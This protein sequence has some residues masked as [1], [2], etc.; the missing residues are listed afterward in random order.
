MCVLVWFG[1]ICWDG[2]TGGGGLGIHVIGRQ[3]DLDKAFLAPNPDG[4]F[5]EGTGSSVHLL[6]D[7]GVNR[8]GCRAVQG[9]KACR[10]S[11][12]GRWEWERSASVRPRLLDT[13]YA[14]PEDGR[15]G[16]CEPSTWVESAYDDE[17]G[18]HVGEG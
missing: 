13:D 7:S 12:V 18:G 5:V 1:L 10:G 17:C 6:V 9:C 2:D 15:V 3:E 16:A 11:S 8:L 4:Y 14:P